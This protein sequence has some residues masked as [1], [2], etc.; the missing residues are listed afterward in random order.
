MVTLGIGSGTDEDMLKRWAS[1]ER[2][3]VK[4]EFDNVDV[5]A[6]TLENVLCSG[7]LHH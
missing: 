7:R 6:D 5:I 1:K 3:Y 4:V 2:Y